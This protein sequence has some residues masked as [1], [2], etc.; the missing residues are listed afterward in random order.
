MSQSL[1]NQITLDYLLNKEKMGSHVIKQREKQISKADLKFNR[2]RIIDLFED[3]ITNNPPEDLSPDVNYAYHTFIKYAID[4]FK[5]VDNDDL[6]QEEYKDIEFALDTCSKP[7]VDFSENFIEENK[8]SMRSV[9]MD[10]PTLDK[11]VKRTSTKKSSK[12]REVDI[13]EQELKEKSIKKNITNIYE[14]N[15]KKMEQKNFK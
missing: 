13:M 10:V 8:I 4:Y 12:T 2:K 11:Y 6:L 9:Q 7:D 15:E 1:I 3:L 14:D 5:V